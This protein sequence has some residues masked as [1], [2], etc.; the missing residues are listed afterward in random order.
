[1]QEGCIAAGSV[2]CDDHTWALGEAAGSLRSPAHAV[3]VFLKGLGLSLGL[4]FRV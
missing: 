3:S 4:G 2:G 1:M